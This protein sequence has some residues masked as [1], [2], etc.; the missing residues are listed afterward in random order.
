MFNYIK[1]KL[2]RQTCSLYDSPLHHIMPTIWLL[3]IIARLQTK[4]HYVNGVLC[5]MLLRVA[6]YRDFFFV[7]SIWQMQFTQQTK[8]VRIF[9]MLQGNVLHERDNLIIN[10]TYTN[11]KFL[12]SKS[13]CK[14]L[15]KCETLCSIIQTGK[16]FYHVTEF[17]PITVNHIC[18]RYISCHIDNKKSI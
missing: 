1:Q 7:C 8:Q 14:G 4:S 18:F 9:T 16:N 6:V 2:K 5:K 13:R 10:V 11:S 12:F 3:I 15:L 17:H